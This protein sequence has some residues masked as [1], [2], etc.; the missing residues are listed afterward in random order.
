MS[1]RYAA[2]LIPTLLA[3]PA[4]AQ[5]DSGRAPP[6]IDPAELDG[7]RLTIGLGAAVVP[8]YEGSDKMVIAPA[9]AAMGRV[10][11]INFTLRGN[12]AWADVIPTPGGPGWDFQLGPLVSI[13]FNRN[14]RIED[15]QV[16]ALG[17]IGKAVEAGGY[18]G[19]GRQGVFTSDYDKFSLSVGYVHDVGTV[20]RSYVITPSLDY[21]T[22]LSRKAYVGIN[23]SADYMG[24]GYADT[25][26]SVTPA[27]S[28]ASGLPVFSAGKGWKDWSLGAVTM[29][30][31]T[32][33][34]TGGLQAVGGVN[35]RRLLGD[36][37]ASP[38]TSIAG[39]RDQWA[40]VLGLAY[41]F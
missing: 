16:Q 11:G 40:G 9:P 33:D 31:L 27:G 2:F 22:P 15:P 20:H 1:V 6:A 23:L 17:K 24:E 5:E 10:S 4:L 8:S 14:S 32:G 25:Y 35:Y 29:I 39:S 38:V 3:G 7:D 28:A 13:N 37:G 34:L 30:S 12:R 36:A 19:I 41:T 26:F 18:V 21:G